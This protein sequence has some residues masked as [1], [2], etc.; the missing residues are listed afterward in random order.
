M[1]ETH[2]KTFGDKKENVS[3]EQIVAACTFAN[4]RGPDRKL[5]LKN[6]V[7]CPPEKI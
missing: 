2:K 5:L 6:F 1:Q 4:P 7:A 3:D